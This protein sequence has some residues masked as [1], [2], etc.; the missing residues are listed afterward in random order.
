MDISEHIKVFCRVR[1]ATP[2]L[3]H[4]PEEP[5][6]EEQSGTYLTGGNDEC[7]SGAVSG[8]RDIDEKLGQC[9]YECVSGGVRRDEQCFRM[10]GFFGPDTTQDTVSE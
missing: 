3:T 5:S 4:S 7:V 10:D 1:P 2:A 9:T 8:I 6:E